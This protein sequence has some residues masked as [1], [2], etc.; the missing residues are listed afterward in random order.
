MTNGGDYTQENQ[1]KSIAFQKYDL[2][3][4]ISNLEKGI[5]IVK[6]GPQMNQS[7]TLL[8]KIIIR[9]ETTLTELKEEL[10]YLEKER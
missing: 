1:T 8:Q 3:Q 10:T 7:D 9:F 6:N 2:Q 5:N 4:S